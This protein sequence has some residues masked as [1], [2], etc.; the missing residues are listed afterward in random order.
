MTEQAVSYW[1]QVLFSMFL[2]VHFQPN[3][4]NM[5]KTLN[6]MCD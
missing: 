3:Q 4:A 2:G 6:K 5:P 1:N